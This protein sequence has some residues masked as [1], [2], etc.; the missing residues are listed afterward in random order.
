[1]II[2]NIFKMWIS[3]FG[4]PKKFLMDNGGEFANSEFV[5]FCENLN[6]VIKTTAAE[7]PW[8]NGIVE[9]HNG[10]IGESVMKIIE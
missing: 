4:S 1:M 8:S 10:M 2:E 3:I 6:I 9:R 7:S 5:D